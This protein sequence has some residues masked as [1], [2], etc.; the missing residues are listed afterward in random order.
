MPPGQPYA[1][2][3]MPG[4]IC[5]GPDA[6]GHVPGAMCPGPYARG[7][8][9]GA[10][11][12]EPCARSHRRG[13]IC[14]EPY[15]CLVSTQRPGGSEPNSIAQDCG[16]SGV[17]FGAAGFLEA[18]CKNACVVRMNKL[19]CLCTRR[20]KQKTVA[21]GLG[22]K[23]VFRFYAARSGHSASGQGLI[24]LAGDYDLY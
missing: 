18:R 12:P 8:M 10:V 16:H 23:L 7:H 14:P 13:A 4:A 24:M 2:G 11:C 6:R 22:F 19:L 15:S 5:Q 20:S 3:R 17:G 21:G 1:R 9:P